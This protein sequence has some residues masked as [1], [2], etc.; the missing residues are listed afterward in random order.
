MPQTTK[1]IA[2]NSAAQNGTTPEPPSERR[3]PELARELLPDSRVVSGGGFHRPA[4]R[5]FRGACGEKPA[6]ASAQ[7]LL[8]V[9]EAEVVNPARQLVQLLAGQVVVVRPRAAW[10]H[11][12][13][14]SRQVI[15]DILQERIYPLL[16]CLGPPH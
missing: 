11:P 16:V 3:Q 7:F 6:D 1:P 4:N 10:V 8:L 5:R 2:E 12:H 9:A 13:H 15:A 14:R